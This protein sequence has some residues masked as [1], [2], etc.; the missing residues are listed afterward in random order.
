MFF[1]VQ[2][3]P[4]KFQSAQLPIHLYGELAKTEEGIALLKKSGDL[5]VFV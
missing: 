2:V 3:L 5:N 1:E 4:K